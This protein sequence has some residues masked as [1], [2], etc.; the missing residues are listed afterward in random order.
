VVQ[1]DAKRYQR[2]SGDLWELKGMR[3]MQCGLMQSSI[4]WVRPD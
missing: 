3:G 4:S 1:N 2:H